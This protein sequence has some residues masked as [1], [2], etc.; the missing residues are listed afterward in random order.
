MLQWQ[1]FKIKSEKE[2][3]VYLC[4]QPK[5]DKSLSKDNRL[6]SNHPLNFQNFSRDSNYFAA[7]LLEFE[8]PTFKVLY[9]KSSFDAIIFWELYS[10][11]EFVSG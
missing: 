2:S 9:N 10:R 7:K 8:T 1:K 6:K 11:K 4:P 5:I 3:E